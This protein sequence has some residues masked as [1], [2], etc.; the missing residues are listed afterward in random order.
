M[1]PETW[2]ASAIA[3]AAG[4]TPWPQFVPEGAALPYVI[5]QRASTDR[6]QTL[7]AGYAR[8][9]GTFDV[10]VFAETYTAAKDLADS[11]RQS[12]A[13]FNDTVEGL[14]I[15]HVHLTDERD[16][17]PVFFDGRDTPTFVIEQ[18]YIIRWEE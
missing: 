7:A 11:I 15:N 12:L 17:D 1:T 9:L 18:T 2:M 16:A 10:T 3:E 6:E 13:N 4:V 5:Y 8:T 14:T